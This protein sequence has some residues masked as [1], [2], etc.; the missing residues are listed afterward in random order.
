MKK[1]LIQ[2]YTGDG[3][4]KTTASIG[5]AIRAKGQGFRVCIIYFHKEPKRWKY[6]EYRVLK[7]LKIDTFGFAKKHPHFYKN[8]KKEEMRKECLKALE[9]IKKIFEKAKY[10]LLILDEILISFR[11]EYLKEEEILEIMDLK[12]KNLELVLTGRSLTKNITDKADYVNEIRKIKHPFD[13]GITGRRG[14]EY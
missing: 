4:G 13:K 1:G 12:P 14:I 9:F 5:L 8:V 6:G 11:E 2:V 7:R 3:K 10:D